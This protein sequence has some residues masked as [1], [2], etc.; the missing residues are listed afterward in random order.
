MHA[1]YTAMEEQLDRATA[2]PVKRLWTQHRD[3]LQRSGALRADLADIG[4]DPDDIDLTTGTCD[5]LESIKAAGCNH[6]GAGLV[7][8]LYC[9]YVCAGAFRWDTNKVNYSM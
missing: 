4:I 3:T 9:R 8:H 7:G 2:A 6:E 5:Y 1:V